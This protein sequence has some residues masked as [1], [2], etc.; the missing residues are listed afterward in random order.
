MSTE[1]AKSPERAIAQQGQEK[2]E[3]Y[4]LSLVFTLL[5]LAIQSATFGTNHW[6]NALELGGWLLFIVSGLAGLY[7]LQWVPVARTTIADRNAFQG[8][9]YTMKELQLKGQSELW[10]LDTQSRQPITDRLANRQKAVDLLDPR[11]T[12]LERRIGVAYELHTWSFVLGLI[13]VAAARAYDPVMSLA[14]HLRG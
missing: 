8:E 11:I 14:T 1:S 4:L 13:S 7:R 9:I 12:Q 10:V 5:A 6:H 2:F 3:F